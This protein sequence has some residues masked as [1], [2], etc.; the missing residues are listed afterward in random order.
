MLTI[1]WRSPKGETFVLN[2]DLWAV[3]SWL[4]CG[5]VW[6]DYIA[7]NL[8]F[9]ISTALMRPR[10]PKQYCLQLDIALWHT[11]LCFHVQIEH[12][13]RSVPLSLARMRSSLVYQ[14]EHSDMVRWYH[15]CG[16]VW[17]GYIAA[18]LNFSISTALM[19]PRRPK[20]YC[21]QLCL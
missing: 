8:N 11:K 19:R 7:A 10:R 9:S 14:I 16:I 20:Q 17:G 15:M 1:N 4:P 6:G 13:I 5:I 12:S 18:N 3:C 21:L 2:M